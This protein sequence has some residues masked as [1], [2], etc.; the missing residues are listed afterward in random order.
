MYK[1]VGAGGGGGLRGVVAH[2][3]GFSDFFLLDDKK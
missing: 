2:P 3:L 1:E